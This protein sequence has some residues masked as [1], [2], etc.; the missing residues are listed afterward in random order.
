MQALTDGHRKL[1]SW[2]KEKGRS[3]SALG[4]TLG[5]SQSAVA[6]WVKVGHRPSPIYR[7]ALEKLGVCLAT[8]WETKTERQKREAL[9][10]L[11]GA[12]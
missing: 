5:V 6:L 9:E 4:R 7:A 1:R 12:A 8:D 3:Q 10:S 11:G 2:L